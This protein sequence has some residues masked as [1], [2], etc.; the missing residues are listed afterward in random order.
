[1][2]P[3]D[4]VKIGC[5]DMYTKYIS[6]NDDPKEIL[7]LNEEFELTE[8]DA[9][10]IGV[11]KN[12]RTPH[13]VHRLNRYME[14][15]LKN[16]STTHKGSPYVQLKTVLSSLDAFMEKYPGYW[17]PD[18]EYQEGLTM[19]KAYMDDLRTQIGSLEVIEIQMQFG[20]YSYVNSSQVNK[21]LNYNY[22]G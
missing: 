8:K 16:K 5:W 11:L 17:V 9:L 22:N 15:V 4:I 3:E 1:M 18:F 14:D 12:V 10:V 19:V 20:V 13:L 7:S 6:K 2:T 21:L